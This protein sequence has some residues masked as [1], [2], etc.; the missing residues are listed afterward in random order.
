M[1]KRTLELL[2]VICFAVSISLAANDPFVGK[3]KLNPS[4]SKM[5]DQMKVSSVGPNKYAFDF[6]GGTETI[7]ADGSDQPGIFATTL[8]VTAEANGVWRVVRKKDGRVLLRATWTL[9]KDGNTLT[10]DFTGFAKDGSAHTVKYAYKRTGSGTG[11]AATWVSTSEANEVFVLEIRPFESN[12]LSFVV[13]DEGV[14]KSMEFDGKDYPLLGP[15]APAGFASS[16]RRVNEH[17]LE[18]TDKINGKIA[19]TQRIELSSDLKTLTMTKRNAGQSE[20]HIS[21]FER[22]P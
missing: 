11:F 17:V 8:A 22:E 12:G 18:I 10:D 3:W 2:L 16:G 14:T 1:F 20:P 9:S 4:K 7:V 6:G 13:A 19:D 5:T 21:V 15:N